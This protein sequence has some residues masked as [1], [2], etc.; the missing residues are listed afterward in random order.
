[1]NSNIIQKITEK[2]RAKLEKIVLLKDGWNE[3]DGQTD[4]QADKWTEADMNRAELI[5]PYGRATVTMRFSKVDVMHFLRH[6]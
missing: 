3:L 2:D 4:K 6:S 5:E 1:M